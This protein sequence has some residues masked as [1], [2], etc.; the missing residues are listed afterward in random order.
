MIGDLFDGDS[1]T[2]SFVAA[3]ATVGSYGVIL[4]V[5]FLLLFVVPFLVFRF[6]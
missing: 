5:L 1:E 4:L 3:V 2:N 6:F